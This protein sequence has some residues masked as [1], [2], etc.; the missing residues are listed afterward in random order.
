MKRK[1]IDYFIRCN[2]EIISPIFNRL[3]DRTQWIKDHKIDSKNLKLDNGTIIENWG[4]ERS[5]FS[6]INRKL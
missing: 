4:L 2:G 6:S 5:E 1:T 3:A